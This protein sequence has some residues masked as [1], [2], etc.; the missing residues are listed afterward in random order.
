MISILYILITVV[1]FIGA[2]QTAFAQN[3]EGKPTGLA[4]LFMIDP[5]T[6]AF[7]LRDGMAGLVFQQGQKRNRCSDLNFGSYEPES[8]S[9]GDEGGRQGVIIDL[10][11]SLDLKGRYG[12]SETVGAGQGFASITASNGKAL[13][14]KDYMTGQLQEM[15]ESA[16]LFGTPA[17]GTQSVPVKLGHIYLMRL[18]DRHDKSFELLAK[19]LVVAYV[20]S[21]S[22]TI[23]WSLM[24]DA[25]NAKL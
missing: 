6:Q 16:K 8:F 23:R 1:L 21:Q 7:C 3:T 12:Y 24:S 18:T 10:G 9:V 14:L 22:V 25:K 15:T 19:L 5:L 20:P 4:T 13:I 17:D 11:K 2:V